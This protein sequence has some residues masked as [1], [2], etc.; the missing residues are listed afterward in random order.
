MRLS[1]LLSIVLGVFVSL[2]LNSDLGLVLFILLPI[3]WLVWAI[4]SRTQGYQFTPWETSMRLAALTVVMFFVIEVILLSYG[5]PRLVF[6]NDRLSYFHRVKDRISDDGAQIALA[7]RDLSVLYDYYLG[8]RPVLKS[9]EGA[10]ALHPTADV[11]AYVFTRRDWDHW[12]KEP[13]VTAETYFYGDRQRSP[14]E[15]MLRVWPAGAPPKPEAAPA[16]STLATTLTLET[17]HGT[18]ATQPGAC[19]ILVFGNSGTRMQAQQRVAKKAYEFAGKAPVDDAILV[20][21]NLYGPQ[22]LD[23]LAFVKAFEEPYRRL[24][25]KGI[26][27]HATL[28]HEDQ[29]YAWLQTLYPPFHMQ[30]ERYYRQSLGGGL[31]DYFAL[32]A[33]RLSNGRTVDPEQLGWLQNELA[34]S[35]APWKVVGL[36][37]PLMTSAVDTRTTR[38]DDVLTSTLLPLF[39]RYQVNIVLWSGGQFYERF[40][41]AEH[42][43]AFFNAGWSGNKQQSTRFVPAPGVRMAYAKRAGFL[44]LSFTPG[45]AMFQAINER[46]EVIDE[47]SLSAAGAQ[48]P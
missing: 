25:K 3:A 24:L 26:V 34:N 38:V 12:L 18:L 43:P 17:Q 30:G 45:Q 13:G 47:G 41:T 6:H 7:D 33:V 16:T 46:G 4:Y 10:A 35:R 5:E 2:L 39:D 29:S 27:F 23:H 19:N 9:G 21:N 31:V 32:D 28:G 14:L 44:A 37:R 11:P 22:V 20:G 48:R 15:A 42:R 8:V 40:A 1:L 36:S